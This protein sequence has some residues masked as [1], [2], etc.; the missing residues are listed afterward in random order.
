MDIAV[1]VRGWDNEYRWYVF[2]HIPESTVN[3]CKGMDNEYPKIVCVSLIHQ[4][5]VKL[6]LG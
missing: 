3:L 2:C 4:S 5:T 6:Y 1:L